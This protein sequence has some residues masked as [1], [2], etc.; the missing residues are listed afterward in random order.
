MHRS[1]VWLFILFLKREIVGYSSMLSS[2]VFHKKLPLNDTDSTLYDV[3]SAYGSLLRF[4]FLR[5][6]FTHFFYGIPIHSMDSCYLMTCVFQS[7]TFVGFLLEWYGCYYAVEAIRTM[8]HNHSK[9]ES[10]KVKLSS[11]SKFFT[12]NLP[13]YTASM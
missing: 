13:H 3:V 5:S 7:S 8:N 2:R 10:R 6:Y 1:P 12:Y 9:A 4:F 11:G